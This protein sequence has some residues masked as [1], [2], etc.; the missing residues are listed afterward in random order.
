MRLKQNIKE[1]IIKY[2]REHFGN[3]VQLYL[4]GSRI[5]DNKKGG[6]IDLFL[7]A[8]YEVNIQNQI[9]FLRDIYKYVTQ[10]KIDLLVKTPKKIEIP[11]YNAARN[12]GVL[13]C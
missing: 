7:D 11:I 1:Q 5:K 8:G 3:K 12:E 9:L 13:L 6:D 4:F 2:S 10:R